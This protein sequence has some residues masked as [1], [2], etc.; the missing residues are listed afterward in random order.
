MSRPMLVPEGEGAGLN[1]KPTSSKI[2]G[3]LRWSTINKA[4]WNTSVARDKAVTNLDILK[5]PRDMIKLGRKIGGGSY[6][7]VYRG[8]IKETAEAVAV[9]V[10]E[11]PSKMSD[12]YSDIA[13]EV[14]LLKRFSNHTNIASF[15]GAYKLSSSTDDW[16]ESAELWISME[17]C[18]VC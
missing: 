5:C 4:K 6:G 9:K 12:D 16:D 2:N 8:V 15:Y 13:L 14:E 17:L 11:L 1:P 10:V 18:M 7:S 3:S